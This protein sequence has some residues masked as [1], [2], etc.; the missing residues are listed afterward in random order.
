LVR[1]SC[2]LLEYLLPPKASVCVCSQQA[3]GQTRSQDLRVEWRIFMRHAPASC[4]SNK[5][6][7]ADE[8]Q[9]FE[10]R[11]PGWIRLDEIV[12]FDVHDFD[13]SKTPAGPL[14]VVFAVDFA[15]QRV[16]GSCERIVART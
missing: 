2:P 12:E 9:E 1:P 13:W 14:G 7:I 8:W 10:L 3:A 15:E 6:R 11:F 4:K 16:A 5:D